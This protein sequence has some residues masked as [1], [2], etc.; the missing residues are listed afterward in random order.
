MHEQQMMCPLCDKVDET[1]DHLLVSC[2]FTRQIWYNI[3]QLF[4][5]QA[6]APQ[7]DNLFFVDWWDEASSRLS[8][9][10]QKGFNSII[11]LGAWLIWKH[12]NYC[13]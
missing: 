5:L 6:V 1:I 9:Q 11:I 12:R 3:L 10:V 8:G 13:L 2:V 4:G 7:M